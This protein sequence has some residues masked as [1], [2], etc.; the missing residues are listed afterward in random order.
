[1]EKIW[2]K[3]GK[4]FATVMSFLPIGEHVIIAGSVCKLKLE[5][6]FTLLNLYNLLDIPLYSLLSFV[7]AFSHYLFYSICQFHRVLVISIVY[8]KGFESQNGQPTLTTLRKF[9]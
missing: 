5:R 6:D 2:K 1:M 9:V 7:L 8:A 3:G 4:Y